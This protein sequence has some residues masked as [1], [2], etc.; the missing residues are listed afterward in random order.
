MSDGWNNREKHGN[1]HS[2]FRAQPG[3]PLC[4]EGALG[5]DELTVQ[6]PTA[7][8]T[9]FGSH[10][11]WNAGGVISGRGPLSSLFHCLQKF[12]IRPPTCKSG[13][14][15]GEGWHQAKVL[16]IRDVVSWAVLAAG[17]WLDGMITEVFSNLNYFMIP[18]FYDLLLQ[19]AHSLEP[20]SCPGVVF[21]CVGCWMQDYLGRTISAL[22][23][24]Q[25]HK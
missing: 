20:V 9:L 24:I 16:V 10:T 3:L 22:A 23:I 12:G 1:T 4:K 19:P 5:R 6:L 7:P 13:A 15:N 11:V 25:S 18:W 17:G 21:L 2:H 14:G 8:G